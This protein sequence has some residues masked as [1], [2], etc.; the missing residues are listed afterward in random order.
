MTKGSDS[1]VTEE[2][3]CDLVAEAKRHLLFL[4]TAHA[5]GVTLSKPSFESIRR[6]S[7]L[8]IPLVGL[9]SKSFEEKRIPKGVS[10]I[11]PPD[12]AWLWHCHRL[13]P[14]QYM[15]FINHELDI[16]EKTN[17]L[18]MNAPLRDSQLSFGKSKGINMKVISFLRR[19]S[20]IT[21]SLFC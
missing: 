11:P 2:F 14:F 3:S 1:K 6:Y 18:S 19:V 7:K 5:L 8:W 12:I 4:K 16:S 21:A 17:L 15:H 13:A 10:L 20:I 9:D